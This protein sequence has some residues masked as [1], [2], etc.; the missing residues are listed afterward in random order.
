M[1]YSILVIE[2]VK[3]N[4]MRISYIPSSLILSSYSS[5][6]HSSILMTSSMGAMAARLGYRPPQ[7]VPYV[8]LNRSDLDDTDA[9]GDVKG[10]FEQ[11]LGYL[12]PRYA[13][14]NN[15]NSDTVSIPMSPISHLQSVGVG[16]GGS[17]V[18][19]VQ[20]IGA[21]QTSTHPEERDQQQE[22]GRE[23]Y[24]SASV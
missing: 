12:G 21:V 15:E 8:G 3:G 1:L 16:V 23:V 10:A 24:D 9:D 13:D 5:T 17:K 2:Y 20:R 14:E 19:T 7:Y 6:P 18:D 22:G 4:E 11:E